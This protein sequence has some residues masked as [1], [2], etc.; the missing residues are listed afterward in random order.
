MKY[1]LKLSSLCTEIAWDAIVL[2]GTKHFL[3]G[4]HYPGA[5]FLVGSTWGH[6]SVVNIILRGNSLSASCPRAKYQGDNFRA[7]NVRGAF[8]WGAIILEGN[9]P[10]GNYPGVQMSGWQLSGM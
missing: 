9:C 2:G 4:V 8:I 1:F 7:S 10:G 3:G 5:I 6:I